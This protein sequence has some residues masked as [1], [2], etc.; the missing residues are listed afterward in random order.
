M[1]YKFVGDGAGV[2]GLPHEITDE[3]ASELGVTDLLQEAVRN[4]NY[5]AQ[6]VSVETAP[7]RKPQKADKKE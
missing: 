7:V 4:G 6:G 2:P 1:K 3:Q 5:A